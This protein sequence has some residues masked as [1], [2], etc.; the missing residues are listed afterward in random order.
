LKRGDR[1]GVAALALAALV[2]GTT[3][4]GSLAAFRS[5]TVSASNTFSAA[6]DLVAPRIVSVV[7]GK[8]EGGLTGAIRAGGSYHVYAQVGDPSPSSGIAWVRADVSAITP[9]ASAV[10]LVA[11]SY[12][13][14]GLSYNYRSAALSASA[15]LGAG[16]SAFSVSS[17]DVAGNQASATGAVNVDNFP[18]AAQDVQTTNG[19]TPGAPDQGDTV[20]FTFSEPIDPV[21]VLP[22][23][24]GAAT[25]V[26]VKIS[27]GLL[28]NDALTVLGPG[29][30]GSVNLGSVN[31][32]RADYVTL[33]TTFGLAGSASRMA[34]SGSSVTITLG[35]PSGLGGLGLALGAG[36]MIWSPSS[37]VTD[38]AG[39]P[40]ATSAAT[41]SGGADK[42]F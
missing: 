27:D 37:A 22:G 7:I 13:A 21:T 10:A 12:Q 41:E 29:G 17:A 32:G 34:L 2:T 40:C 26:V 6:A 11:G 30:V 15:A 20:T 9:G 4:G 24:N 36:T 39:N 28:G 33:T 5:A 19:G 31:L 14:G 8:T 23:W 3:T 18:P 38:A 16:T 35:T 25:N 1:T 42:D